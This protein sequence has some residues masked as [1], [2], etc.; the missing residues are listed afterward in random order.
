MENVGQSQSLTT[1]SEEIDVWWGAYAGRRLVPEL[2]L[3]GVITAV[4]FGLAWYFREWHG[5]VVRYAVQLA[6]GALWIAELFWS[7]YRLI[8]C[9]Y[10]LTTRRLLYYR[11]LFHPIR[12]ELDLKDVEA[13]VIE[14]TFFDRLLGIGNIL[15]ASRDNPRSIVFEAVRKAKSIAKE[16][17]RRAE[18]IRQGV[19]SAV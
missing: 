14:Q 17:E 11:G 19:T 7:A 9:G 5:N 13:V 15:I 8:A 10:R 12:Q 3:C 4:L 1:L 6:M 16:I 2:V 18:R